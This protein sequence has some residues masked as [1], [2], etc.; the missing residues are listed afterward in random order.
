MSLLPWLSGLTR[1]GVSVTNTIFL[2]LKD[3]QWED[4]ILIII[5][6]FSLFY[7]IC[8]VH[9]QGNYYYSILS[10]TNL[11]SD[12]NV[13]SDQQMNPNREWKYIN[14]VK[15]LHVKYLKTFG[16]ESLVT[17]NGRYC[18]ENTRVLSY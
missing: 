2:H 11:L 8:L 9:V 6:M 10:K 4:H 16:R 7:F 15:Q 14:Q 1:T 13:A 5:S 17:T 18:N 3:T 12:S